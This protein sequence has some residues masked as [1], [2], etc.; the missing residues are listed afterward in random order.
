GSSGK[1]V[2]GS[3]KGMLKESESKV[4]IIFDFQ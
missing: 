1:C 4:E 3:Q 2:L